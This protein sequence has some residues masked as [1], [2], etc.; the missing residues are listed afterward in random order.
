MKK[1]NVQGQRDY[2]TIHHDPTNIKRDQTTTKKTAK[3]H[4]PCS[5]PVFIEA[6]RDNWVTAGTEQS[7]A[8]QRHNPWKMNN[9]LN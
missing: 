6:E 4:H 2:R 9:G 8:L 5:L 1:H 3:R 7:R